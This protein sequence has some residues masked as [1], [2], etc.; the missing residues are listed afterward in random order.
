[1]GAVIVILFSDYQLSRT[2]VTRQRRD[3]QK[4]HQSPF[5]LLMEKCWSIDAVAGFFA[6]FRGG[7]A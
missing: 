6:G 3:T 5:S 4:K 7:F 2:S 1:V